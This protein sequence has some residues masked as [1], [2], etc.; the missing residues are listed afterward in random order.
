M[1]VIGFDILCLFLIL[2]YFWDGVW[3]YFIFRC[4]MGC[5]MCVLFEN[6][7]LMVVLCVDFES[8]EVMW[9]VV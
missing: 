8:Y 6:D 9:G 4:L 7:F 2:L 1:R 3:G 5:F